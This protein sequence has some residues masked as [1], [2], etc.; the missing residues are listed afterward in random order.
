MVGFVP[1]LPS[2]ATR[3]LEEE[4]FSPQVRDVSVFFPT[5]LLLNRG[6]M[7]RLS[8]VRAQKADSNVWKNLNQS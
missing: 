8:C 6:A 4:D 2:D 5:K 7:L 3:A 1:Q